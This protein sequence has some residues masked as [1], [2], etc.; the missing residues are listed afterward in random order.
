M[1]EF[2]ESRLGDSFV[3]AVTSSFSTQKQPL[4]GGAVRLTLRVAVWT[5]QEQT[6]CQSVR[7]AMGSVQPPAI[8]RLREQIQRLDGV[9][10]CARGAAVWDRVIDSRPAGGRG[11]GAG[12]AARA[13]GGNATID[14]A[15]ATLFA[16]GIAARAKGKIL[17]C[18]PRQDLLAPALAQVGLAPDGVI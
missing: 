15:A 2:R 4:P 11:P 17:W 13:G 9:L 8:R 6:V 12:G 14:G 1:D 5:Y 3:L 7:E 16:A 10:A 18:I